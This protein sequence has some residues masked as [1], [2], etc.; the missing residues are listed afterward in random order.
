MHRGANNRK[1]YAKNLQ[2]TARRKQ[3]CDATAI[4]QAR[5]CN[6]RTLLA[7]I[8]SRSVIVTEKTA[9]DRFDDQTKAKRADFI[10]EFSKFAQIIDK[11]SQKPYND[12]VTT[13]SRKAHSY[14]I[15]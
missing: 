7:S 2:N 9:S 13:L 15:S 3:N 4:L 6:L 1:P 14:E 8:G 5:V 12:T 10:F 11:A